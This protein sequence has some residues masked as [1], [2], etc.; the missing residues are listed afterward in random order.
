M[1]K[2]GGV[3][4]EG[5][6]RDDDV[7]LLVR[8]RRSLDIL[9]VK[10]KQGYL[11]EQVLLANYTIPAFTS[12]AF[13]RRRH[14]WLL[15][16]TSDC[17]LLLI[18]W[19]LNRMKGWVGLVDWPVADGFLSAL[20]GVSCRPSAGQGKWAGQRPTFYHYATQPTCISTNVD[21]QLTH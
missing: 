20:S 1:E 13:N 9:S 10:N 19:T 17:S 11:R 7:E 8:E 21:M 2:S 6:C 14:H 3:F 5:E 12:Y 4:G 15:W 18:Y 16:R